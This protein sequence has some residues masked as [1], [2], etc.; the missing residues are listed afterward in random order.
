MFRDMRRKKQEL[1]IASCEKVINECTSGVLALQGDNEYPYAVPLSYCYQNGKLYFHSSA[2]GHKLDAIKNNSKCSFCIISKDEVVPEKFTTF[3]R[4][5]ICF[6]RI[7]VLESTEDKMKVLNLLSDKYSPD[8]AMSAR[9]EEITT[10][11]NR[12]AVLEL[13]IEHMTGKQCIEFVKG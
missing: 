9:E 7:K 8:V 10:S 6:G 1:S 13:D 12:V 4:S 3:F 11:L 5:V 2:E